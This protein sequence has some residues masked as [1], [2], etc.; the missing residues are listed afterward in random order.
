LNGAPGDQFALGMKGCCKI[1][2]DLR[3]DGDE[4]SHLFFVTLGWAILLILTLNGLLMTFKPLWMRYLPGW[5][6]WTGPFHGDPGHVYRYPIPLWQ[7]RFK[8]IIYL[9]GCAFVWWNVW[10]RFAH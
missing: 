1:A 10:K 7:F 5:L 6:Q 8:G 9:V 3:R 4:M 2:L